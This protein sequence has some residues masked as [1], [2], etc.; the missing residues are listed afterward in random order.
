MGALNIACTGSV[1]GFNHRRN[2]AA[3]ALIEHIPKKYEEVAAYNDHPSIT[4]EDILNLFDKTLADLGGLG[5]R[6]SA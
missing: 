1:E 6:V 4:H 3:R 2:A 5:D